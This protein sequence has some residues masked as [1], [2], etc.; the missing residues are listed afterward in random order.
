MKAGQELVGCSGGD[1]V[2][3][4]VERNSLQREPQHKKRPGVEESGPSNSRPLQQRRRVNEK[5]NAT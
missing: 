1:A 2:G 5:G 3:E 4:G